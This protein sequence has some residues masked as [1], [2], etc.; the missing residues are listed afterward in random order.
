MPAKY[1]TRHGVMRNLGEFEAG[2]GAAYLR[3]QQ[4]VLRSDRGL[5]LGDVLCEASPRAVQLITEPTHGQI[6]R[7]VTAEDRREAARLQEAER[8][9]FDACGRYIRQR[10]LQMELVDVEHI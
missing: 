1:I 5:E 2:E 3:G 4:V 10:H 9:E 7:A 6:V 8:A